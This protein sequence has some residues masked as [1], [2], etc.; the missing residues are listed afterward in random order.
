M[1]FGESTAGGPTI[2]NAIAAIHNFGSAEGYTAAAQRGAADTGDSIAPTVYGQGFKGVYWYD[3]TGGTGAN[4]TYQST[5]NL[6]PNFG[7]Q[8]GWTSANGFDVVKADSTDAFASIL[9]FG[10]SGIV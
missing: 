8:Q 5:A 7:S 1:A 4:P 9:G 10:E 2:A 3:A 6:Y